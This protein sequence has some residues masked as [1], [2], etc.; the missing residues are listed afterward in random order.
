MKEIAIKIDKLGAYYTLNK[1]FQ[2]SKKLWALKDIS[3]T[4]RR[5]EVFGILGSNGAGKSTLMKIMAGIAIHHRGEFYTDPDAKVCLLSLGAGFEQSLT[6]REN[7]ILN[8]LFF[9]LH[10]RTIEKR[11]DNIIDFA[12]LGDFI[13]QPLYT[14]STGMRSR[15]SFSV[16]MEVDPD[17]LLIDEVMAVGDQNFQNRSEERI[18]EKMKND[19]TVVLISHSASNIQS[20]CSR[21]MWMHQGTSQ[22]EGDVEPVLLAYNE[23]NAN[24]KLLR[25]PSQAIADIT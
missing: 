18:K 21:A 1:K 19:M 17:I 24:G 25:N 13:D 8:G 7:A 16:A 2:G 12:G 6:G 11:M 14:Y 22:L 9:G 5:G 23:F 10:K 4:I 3:V 20:I 15:L